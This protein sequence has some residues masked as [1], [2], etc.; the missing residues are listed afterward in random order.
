MRGFP[1][2]HFVG[3]PATVRPNHS[4]TSGWASIASGSE[5]SAG[6][7]SRASRNRAT[8]RRHRSSSRRTS[9]SVRPEIAWPCAQH[10]EAV[11][12]RGPVEQADA[13]EDSEQ[14]RLSRQPLLLVELHHSSRVIVAWIV[15][16][17]EQAADMIAPPHVS[18]L[19]FP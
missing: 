8:A 15:G 16:V 7:S 5:G 4:R 9:A 3:L 11:A 18:D 10:L 2:S 14:D 1:A 6:A 17:G 12:A 19:R 13:M